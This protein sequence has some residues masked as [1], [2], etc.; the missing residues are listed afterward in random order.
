MAREKKRDGVKGRINMVWDPGLERRVP[1]RFGLK[2]NQTTL[3]QQIASALSAD[4]GITSYIRLHEDCPVSHNCGSTNPEPDISVADFEI[5]TRY[6]ESLAPP[7]PRPLN[8][9][10]ETGQRV[11]AE[12]G[13]NACH[14]DTLR[15]GAAPFAPETADKVIH[16]Y[17]DLLLHD[18]GAGLADGRPDFEAGGREWRTA[19]LWGIG[20]AGVVNDNATYLHDGRARSLTEAILWHGGEAEP[21][22]KRFAALPRDLREAVLAFLEAI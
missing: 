6:I 11:F 12:I 18:M 21:A 4:I 8:A 13:C 7:P 22:R 5:L 15:T 17:S 10:G 2:A 19:P 3:V 1:G 9:M 14:R 20:L 16:P